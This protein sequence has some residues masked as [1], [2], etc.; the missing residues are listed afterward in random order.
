[1]PGLFSDTNAN[2]HALQTSVQKRFAHGYSVQGSYT[3][4]KSIDNRSQSLL[5]SGAQDPNNWGRAERGLSDFN[6]GQI[7]AINGIW[8][9]PT[10]QGNG[11]LKAVAGGGG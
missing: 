10:P 3:W 9:I 1:M 11:F 5:G 7:F 2:Y 4:G 6:V 8:D